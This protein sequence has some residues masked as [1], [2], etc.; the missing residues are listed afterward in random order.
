MADVYSGQHHKLTMSR[1]QGTPLSADTLAELK[2]AFSKNIV[3]SVDMNNNNAAYENSNHCLMFESVIVLVA[4]VVTT[5]FTTRTK[6][7]R[8]ELLFT[9]PKQPLQL[10]C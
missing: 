5:L 8:C 4:A 6:T 7:S 2:K 1:S 9:I 10:R 3:A